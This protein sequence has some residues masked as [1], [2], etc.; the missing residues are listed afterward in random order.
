MILKRRAAMLLAATISL[1]SVSSITTIPTHA[2]SINKVNNVI[3]VEAGKVVG[4]GLDGA[5]TSSHSAHTLV[6]DPTDGLKVGDKI[7]L[8]IKNGKWVDNTTLNNA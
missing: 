6:I 8:D 7:V 1:T 3:Q 4:I 2:I 5:F